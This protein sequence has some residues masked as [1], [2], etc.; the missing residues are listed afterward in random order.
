M[1]VEWFFRTE[2]PLPIKP[3]PSASWPSSLTASIICL[4]IIHQDLHSSRPQFSNCSKA[5]PPAY[6]LYSRHSDQMNWFAP[7][8][9]SLPL[10]EDCLSSSATDLAKALTQVD[11]C[12]FETVA[13]DT[14]SRR[15]Y[16]FGSSHLLVKAKHFC[17]GMLLWTVGP[18]SVP[19]DLHIGE[20][21]NYRTSQET[22]VYFVFSQELY[23]ARNYYSLMAI[24]DGFCKYIAVGSNIFRAFAASRTI[25]TPPP[26]IP[27]KVLPLI[28]PS[29]NFVSYRQRYDQHPGIPF[30]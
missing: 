2:A 14:Y 28:D 9:T 13:R 24:L 20:N 17:V 10:L 8:E 26:L 22:E 7:F 6:Q 25:V 5:I 23:E 19:S 21:S 27:P 4:H 18:S 3:F 12:L 29:H 1:S 15:C 11:K 30:L 16:G